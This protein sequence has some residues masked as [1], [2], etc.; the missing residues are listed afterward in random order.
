MRSGSGGV[1]VG[2][3]A[4]GCGCWGA[5]VGEVVGAALALGVVDADGEGVVGGTLPGAGAGRL[6]VVRAGVGVTSGAEVWVVRVASTTTVATTAVST[7][8][9]TRPM[10]KSQPR[11][12]PGPWPEPGPELAQGSA[13]GGT[14]RA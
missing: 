5:A 7:R 11:P 14:A 8:A 9:L 4:V 12:R 3:D 13:G 6:T 2:A 10:T 1:L